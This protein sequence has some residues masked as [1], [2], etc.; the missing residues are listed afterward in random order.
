MKSGRVFWGTFF[1]VLGGLFL[2]DRFTP[3]DIGW[4]EV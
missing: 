1:L 2:L 4:W 3:I